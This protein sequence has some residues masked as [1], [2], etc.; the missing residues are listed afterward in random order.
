MKHTT[1]SERTVAEYAIMDK[2][3]KEHGEGSVIQRPEALP[4][5]QENG[6][7][8]PSR[9]TI[10]RL[11]AKKCDH[12]NSAMHIHRKGDD[13]IFSGCEP[14]I[15]DIR[16]E[17]VGEDQALI[18][19]R[20]SSKAVRCVGCH[21]KHLLRTFEEVKDGTGQEQTARVSK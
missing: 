13:I 19:G 7:S 11:V 9:P 14:C 18:K 15:I 16:L 17:R 2:V 8:N 4:F 6:G 1:K 20:Q 21:H 5:K 10:N 3:R 12:C